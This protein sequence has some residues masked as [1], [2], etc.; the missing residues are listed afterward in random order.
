MTE[1]EIVKMLDATLYTIEKA[2]ADDFP[3]NAHA[4]TDA[5]IH[6]EQL[7]AAHAED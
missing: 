5:R 3:D 7:L 6:V 1:Q 2:Q 4:W